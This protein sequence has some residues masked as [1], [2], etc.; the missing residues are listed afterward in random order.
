MNNT[1]PSV[2]AAGGEVMN[3]KELQEELAELWRK[4]QAAQ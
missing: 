3:V 2:G 4:L 1:H